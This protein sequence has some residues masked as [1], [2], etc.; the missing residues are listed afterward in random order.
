MRNNPTL[1][2]FYQ[3]NPE[4]LSANIAPDE[5]ALLGADKENFFGLTGPGTRIWQLLEEPMMIEQIC[6]VLV[7]EF[8]VERDQCV[9]ETEEYVA[10]LLLNKLI[11]QITQ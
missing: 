8:D 10:R 7:R 2:A 9:K 1:P 11:I 4:V 5:T 6:D 3:C